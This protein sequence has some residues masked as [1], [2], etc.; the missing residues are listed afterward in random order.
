M[1]LNNLCFVIL[2]FPGSSSSR[3]VRPWEMSPKK[4]RPTSPLPVKAR[5]TNPFPVMLRFT[6][7]VTPFGVKPSSLA[8][9][10]SGYYSNSPSTSPVPSGDHRSALTSPED[11]RSAPMDYNTIPVYSYY[12]ECHASAPARPS[13]AYCA[14]PA[15]PSPAYCAAP[16]QPSPAYCA[17]PAQPSPAYCAAPARPSPAYC[18]APAQ[19]SPAYCAAP[20]RPSPAYCAAPTRPSPAYCAAKV[21]VPKSKTFLN[22]KT[23][24]MMEAWYLDNIGHPYPSKEIVDNICKHG[25][26]TAR[27]VRQWIVKKRKSTKL[28]TIRPKSLKRLQREFNSH[29]KQRQRLY[30]HSTPT[31][32]RQ[33]PYRSSTGLPVQVPGLAPHH[34]SP[35]IQYMMPAPYYTQHLTPTMNFMPNHVPEASK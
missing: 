31:K 18:A 19:P 3:I 33:H 34:L 30:D 32:Q 5:P 24:E 23:I 13:P 20:A 25:N 12:T 27:Q 22:T 9:C 4:T 26:V 28:I 2:Y 35:Y 14:A 8:A 29:Q 6:E 10:D 11:R 16:A 17:A 21:R 7:P 1:N 15:Q